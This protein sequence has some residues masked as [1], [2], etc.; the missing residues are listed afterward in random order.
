MSRQDSTPSR[1]KPALF[2]AGLFSSPLPEKSSD[3][4]SLGE[5]GDNFLSDKMTSNEKY[6]NNN[7]LK[8]LIKF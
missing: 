8:M 6:I 3:L 5:F 2:N 7:V 4:S 1:S